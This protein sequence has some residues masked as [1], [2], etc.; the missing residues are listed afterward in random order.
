MIIIKPV[1][2]IGPS[3]TCAWLRIP[4][5]YGLHHRRIEN[6]VSHQPSAECRGGLV[7]SNCFPNASTAIYMNQATSLTLHLPYSDGIRW[8][9]VRDHQHRRRNALV[10]HGF[11]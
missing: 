5:S 2:S 4:R 8:I 10:G 6:V 11:A 1:L 3:A 7:L 9:T